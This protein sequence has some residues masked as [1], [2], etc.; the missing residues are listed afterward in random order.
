M[1]IAHRQR[2]AAALGV[3]LLLLFVMT[4]V[5][6]F[7]SRNLVFEQRSSAN[8]ARSTQAFEAAEAGLQW[9][10]AMLNRGTTI[11]ADCEPGAV[12][13]DTSFRDRFLAYDAASGRFTPRTWNDA[14]A[15]R[16]LQA[17]C[18]LGENGW[19]CSCPSAGPPAWS[20]APT[21]GGHPAFVLQFVAVPRSGIVQLVATGCDGAIPACLPGSPSA[22]PG[23]ASARVQVLLGLLPALATVPVAAL[24]AGTDAAVDGERLAARWLGLDRHRWQ[25][26]PGVRLLD[27]TADCTAE[28]AQAIGPEAAHPMVWISGDLRVGGAAAFGSSERPV[29]L[30]V[31]GQIQLGSEVQ[32]HGAIVSLAATWNGSSHPDAQLHGALIALGN[33]G[34]NGTPTITYDAD[35]LARL[36]G[37]VGSF[38]RVPGSWR[39]F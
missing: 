36:H 29:L 37:Q 14:G 2:G 8:Q 13:G 4:L 26:L 28:L 18:V 25:Q 22:S 3:T 35:A 30:V 9:A 20:A 11:G 5:A 12:P 31:E 24:T 34:G 27:C 38:T 33:A 16:D 15:N 7:A 32:L 39:D 23:G 21:G 19:S 10:Q 6:G 17:A 1:K